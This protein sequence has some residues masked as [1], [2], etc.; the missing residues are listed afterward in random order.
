[1]KPARPRTR[2][3]VKLLLQ[4]DSEVD[5]RQMQ[6]VMDILEGNPPPGAYDDSPIPHVEGVPCASRPWGSASG[7]FVGATEASAEICAGNSR[8]PGRSQGLFLDDAL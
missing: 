5:A 2:A 8:L 1:M 4:T 7:D 3:V 6:L